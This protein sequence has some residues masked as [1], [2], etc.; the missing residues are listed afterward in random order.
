MK[1]Y[2]Y[3]KALH[4]SPHLMASGMI[5]IEFQSKITR[6]MSDRSAR[7]VLAQRIASDI[8][9]SETPGKTLQKWRT[10]LEISQVT[11][12]NELDISP[13]VVSDYESGR[14]ESPGIPVIR[15]MINALLSIDQSRGGSH[16]RQYARILS[17]GFDKDVILDQV[18]YPSPVTMDSFNEAI[19]AA[20]IASGSQKTITG[21]TVVDSLKAITEFSTDDFYRLYGQSTNRAIVFTNITRGESPLVAIRVVNPKPSAVVLHGISSRDIWENAEELARIDGYSLSS[22]DV[23]LDEMLDAIGQIV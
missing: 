10:D 4:R 5:L 13:S 2:F 22:T 21:H 18:E 14:R 20:Q 3:K 19:E 9:L 1:A 16:I 17:A 6:K 15:R 12:A 11:L 8:L 23:P 7:Y